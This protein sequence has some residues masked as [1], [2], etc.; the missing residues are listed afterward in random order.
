MR[1]LSTVQTATLTTTVSTLVEADPRRVSLV[2]SPPITAGVTVTISTESSFNDGE[3][4]TVFAGVM[5]FWL[6]TDWFGD[7][8]SKRW[9]GR[10]SAGSETIGYLETVEV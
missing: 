2:I 5:P 1:R 4:L 7:A 3:G 9:Y 8:V 10:V 6:T